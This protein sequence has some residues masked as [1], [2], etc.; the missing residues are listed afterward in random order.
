VVSQTVLINKI[1]LEMNKSIAELIFKMNSANIVL[2]K[3]SAISKV[4]KLTNENVKGFIS[5]YGRD[6]EAF[7]KVISNIDSMESLDQKINKLS[8][9][10]TPLLGTIKKILDSKLS[11]YDKQIAIETGLIEYELDYFN[12]HVDTPSARNQI[13]HK[14]YPQFKKGYDGLIREYSLNKYY[15]IRKD[16]NTLKLTNFDR[17][18]KEYY[19][20]IVILII[21]YLGSEKCISYSFS[22][23]INLLTGSIEEKKRTNIVISL[24]H[25]FIRLLKT[26]KIDEKVELE[27]IFPL[28]ELKKLCYKIDDAGLFWLGDTLLHL[29]TD[30]CDIVVEDLVRNNIKDSYIILKINDKFVSELTIGSMSLL[31]FPMLT[32]PREIEIK[33]MYYPYINTDSTNL[34]LFEGGLIK[35]KDDDT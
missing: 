26:I 23:V 20:F 3:Q 18:N 19:R 31:Q 16:I 11:S 6:I 9:L 8:S 33:G 27:R 35:S 22:Q 24:G 10:N 34:H 2:T 25:K 13:L 12:K 28:G 4:T 21:M 15:K 5:D 32:C 30:N 14:V 29:I 1:I 7:N 17:S